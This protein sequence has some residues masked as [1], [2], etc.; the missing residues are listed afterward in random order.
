MTKNRWQ[1]S[2]C[3]EQGRALLIS[4]IIIRLT[5]RNYCTV[6]ALITCREQMVMIEINKKLTISRLAKF[7]TK[8]GCGLVELK[9]GDSNIFS[10]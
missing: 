5:Q 10:R 9:V 2:R 4:P 7:I 8:S 1:S 6:P 3:S